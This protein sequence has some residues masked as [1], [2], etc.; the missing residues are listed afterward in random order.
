MFSN[1]VGEHSA[2]ILFNT[3]HNIFNEENKLEILKY[4][5]K[6]KNEDAKNENNFLK[7]E[8]TLKKEVIKEKEVNLKKEK[9]SLDDILIEINHDK[10]EENDIKNYL[11]IDNKKDIKD[12]KD[13]IKD[14][15]KKKKKIKKTYSSW[16]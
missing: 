14:I 8:V 15:K 1:N 10:K 2:E 3:I 4:N 16:D 13:S 7:K 6:F 9:S 5:Q 11:S 12:T